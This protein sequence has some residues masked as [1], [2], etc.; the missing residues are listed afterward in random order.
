MAIALIVVGFFVS[1]FSMVPDKKRNDQSKNY[2]RVNLAMS[3]LQ[4][5]RKVN[6]HY[7]CPASLDATRTDPEYGHETNCE[8]DT[9]AS[10]CLR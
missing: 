9:S 3:S 10:R 8:V 6:G 4:E 7:P 2:D 5:F 1:A